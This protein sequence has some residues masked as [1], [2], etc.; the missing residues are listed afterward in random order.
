MVSSFLFIKKKI[1][2]L[3]TFP[4]VS[5]SRLLT[6]FYFLE[7]SQ[8][9]CLYIYISLLWFLEII[10]LTANSIWTFAEI[11]F[12]INLVMNSDL[13]YQSSLAIKKKSGKIPE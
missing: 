9:S 1:H 10:D 8:L 11:F 2:V 3:I 13:G 5:D 7:R 12:I 6:F 4:I